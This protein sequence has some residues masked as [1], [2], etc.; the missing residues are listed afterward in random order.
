MIDDPVWSAG[1]NPG[2]LTELEV[3][4]GVVGDGGAQ[5]VML[6]PSS[7]PPLQ[8]LERVLRGFL[9]RP[10]CVIAFSGGRDSSALLATA[11]RVS[12]RDGLAE[13]IAL[14]ARWPGDARANEDDWQ[15]L[16]VR[17]LGLT[18]WEIIEPRDDLDLLGPV[19]TSALRRHGLLWPA[20]A[21]ALLPLIRRAAGGT[22]VTGEGG[23]QVLGGWA[24]ARALASLRSRH[25]PSGKD[26]APIAEAL[27]P[28]W[29]RWRVVSRFDRPYQD[30]LHPP[31]AA[32][33]ARQW[34]KVAANAPLRWERHLATLLD[35][36]DLLALLDT[37][38]R[39]SQDEDATYAAP[40]LEPAFVASVAAAGG[41]I[42]IGDRSAAMASIFG[43][44]LPRA[45]LSRSTKASFGGI[46]WGPESRT[47]ARSW[48]GEG[49]DPGLVDGER[50]RAAW[51]TDVPVYG[52][53]LPLH[54]AWLATNPMSGRP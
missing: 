7:T 51:L 13:P 50:L 42:G 45:V 44:V 21:Y 1:A 25:R 4:A 53:A 46:F 14:T 39:L 23:D 18:N 6:P 35:G 34:A 2:K 36:R 47:F 48:T 49:L 43:E 19:A 15:E 28:R 37:L 10:P 27:L 3:A 17:G 26:L 12:R 38:A 5:P 40:L 11:L 22:L 24:P 52:A 30:W 16:V 29:L 20:P 33:Y 31:V 54:A 9:E 8:V 41:H 32:I